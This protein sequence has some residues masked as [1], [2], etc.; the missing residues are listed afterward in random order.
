VREDAALLEEL[1]GERPVRGRLRV[2]VRYG[3]ADLGGVELLH[4]VEAL[5]VDH[6]VGDGGPGRPGADPGVGGLRGAVGP[7]D[8]VEV[9]GAV[10]A[11]AGAPASASS[12]ATWLRRICRRA[13]FRS[14]TESTSARA[15]SRSRTSSRVRSA[16]RVRS[17]TGAPPRRARRG[18]AAGRAAP[19]GAA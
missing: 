3:G 6:V 8:A 11:G 18:A 14:A 2:G 10:A 13:R 9:S 4:A 16:R 12:R 17:L 5:E 1:L 7:G 15:A 19:S